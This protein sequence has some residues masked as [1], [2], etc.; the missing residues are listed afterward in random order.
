M[1]ESV[2]TTESASDFLLDP[3]ITSTNQ[4]SPYIVVYL[5]EVFAI[6]KVFQ[7]F[8]LFV[9]FCPSRS[10]FGAHSLFLISYKQTRKLCL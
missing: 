2:N 7:E 1:S 3:A 4:V 6:A 9:K 10:T 5:V 8:A